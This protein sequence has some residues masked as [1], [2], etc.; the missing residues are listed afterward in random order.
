MSADRW[1]ECPVCYKKLRTA[2]KAKR[3]KLDADYGAISASKWAK[4]K[5][6]TKQADN[7]TATMREDFHIGFARGTTIEWKYS[8]RCTV[9][10]FSLDGKAEVD[11]KCNNS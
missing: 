4:H 10:G 5:E 6:A 11:L 2:L 1:T 7:P 3:K 8:C 9:C